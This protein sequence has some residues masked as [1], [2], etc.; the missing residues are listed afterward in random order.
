M[1][2]D[3]KPVTLMTVKRL[4]TLGPR[5]NFFSSNFFVAFWRKFSTPATTFG[6]VALF[7]GYLYKREIIKMQFS[8][9]FGLHIDEL[10]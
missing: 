10:S 4:R 7:L 9:N 1:T 2:Q 6:Q 5:P 3:D 8:E